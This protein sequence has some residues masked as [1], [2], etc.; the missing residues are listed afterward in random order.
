MFLLHYRSRCTPAAFAVLGEIYNAR[1]DRQGRGRDQGELD[2]G[3]KYPKAVARIVDDADVLLAAPSKSSE[4]SFISDRP[5]SIALIIQYPLF[6]SAVVVG[7]QRSSEMF[8]FHKDVTRSVYELRSVPA[9]AL[10]R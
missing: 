9:Q 4:A 8:G 10:R 7:V 3:A 1:G 6:V 5:I 2:Y